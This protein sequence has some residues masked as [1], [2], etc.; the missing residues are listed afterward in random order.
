MGRPWNKHK[1]KEHK[2]GDRWAPKIGV[3][4]EW[5]VVWKG[6]LEPGGLERKLCGVW[7]SDMGRVGFR[8]IRG[9]ILLVLPATDNTIKVTVLSLTR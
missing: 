9:I 6:R 4:L 2:E 5:E 7:C 1:Q 8:N 3:K